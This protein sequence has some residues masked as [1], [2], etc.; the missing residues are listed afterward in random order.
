MDDPDAKLMSMLISLLRL[1]LFR[2]ESEKRKEDRSAKDRLA[3]GVVVVVAVVVLPALCP[4]A[5]RGKSG[6]WKRGW[7]SSSQSWLPSSCTAASSCCCCSMASKYFVQ[8]G[9]MVVPTADCCKSTVSMAAAACR[10]KVLVSS[11]ANPMGT[12]CACS[13]KTRARTFSQYAVSAAARRSRLCDEKE[14]LLWSIVNCEL[15]NF[16]FNELRVRSGCI[17]NCGFRRFDLVFEECR[18]MRDGRVRYEMNKKHLFCIMIK[19]QDHFILKHAQTHHAPGRFTRRRQE[20]LRF[21]IIMQEHT[22]TSR[23]KRGRRHSCVTP[24]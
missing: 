2:L 21:G 9:T 12:L 13:G 11:D 6:V 5:G 3:A 23:S 1:L 10:A 17:L 15:L 20:P 24:V 16:V 14:L 7:E 19:N 22:G 8:K 18:G 4:K